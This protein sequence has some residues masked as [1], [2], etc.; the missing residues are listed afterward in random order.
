MTD[1]HSSRLQASV[2]ANHR[3]SPF[4]LGDVVFR[5]YP[6]G[7]SIHDNR[8]QKR[9][10]D[11][12]RRLLMQSGGAL[13][14]WGEHDDGDNL[15]RY[16]L[17]PLPYTGI[18]Y[19]IR[20]AG[21]I[22]RLELTRELRF[23]R[24]FH[25][26]QLAFLRD[27]RGYKMGRPIPMSVSPYHHSRGVHSLDVYAIMQLIIWN[28]RDRL[29]EEE[30]NTLLQAALEHD[31]KTPAN[32][33]PTMAIDPANL[34]EEV[35]FAEFLDEPAFIELCREYR[36][37]PERLVATVQGRDGLLSTLLDYADKIAYTARDASR[38]LGFVPYDEYV[39]AENPYEVVN[40]F[41]CEN[42]LAC[43]VWEHVRV[44]EDRTSVV[45]TDARHLNT[46]LTLRALMHWALY[47]NPFSR[48][49]EAVFGDVIT[50]TMYEQGVL[51]KSFLQSATDRELDQCIA[52]YVCLDDPGWMIGITTPYVELFEK[53]EEALVRARALVQ[54]GNVFCTIESITREPKIGA[55]FLVRHK[56]ADIS[57][58]KQF[59]GL[60]A[61]LGAIVKINKPCRLYYL[62][63]PAQLSPEI[64][65][66]LRENRERT[67]SG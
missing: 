51:E 57:F 55:H 26:K 9:N 40:R 53:K 12:Y 11:H 67:F 23:R 17:G 6:P 5:Q 13:D 54:A 50:R 7:L 10:P 43:R 21:L 16:I 37:N 44:T 45:C 61:K 56:G 41:L 1:V 32:G 63:D 33:D 2:L 60:T 52:A 35:C 15:T 42:P 47:M 39:Q 46:F 49:Q 3:T 24:L 22:E 31:L 36:V 27:Y 18:S 64:L 34:S 28:N 30:K 48:M 38:F 19:Y 65:E 29:T 20:D 62:A 14:K 25:V 58:G 8:I 59:P 4:V 66:V